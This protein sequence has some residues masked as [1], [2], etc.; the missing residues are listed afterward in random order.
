M[1]IRVGVGLILAGFILTLISPITSSTV[2]PGILYCVAMSIFATGMII[3]M[4]GFWRSGK[5]F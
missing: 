5:K 1:I 3:A 4:M 2:R